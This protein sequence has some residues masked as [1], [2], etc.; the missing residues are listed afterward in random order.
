MATEAA[1]AG[2]P[3]GLS[4]GPVGRLRNRCLGRTLEFDAVL[5]RS[6]HDPAGALCLHLISRKTFWTA[7]IDPKN[8]DVMVCL[9]P[10]PS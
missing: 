3:L 10:G 9:P 7:L 8:A 5:R 6:G 4:F 2:I 1:S